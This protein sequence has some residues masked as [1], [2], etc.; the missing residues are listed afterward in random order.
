MSKIVL[1]IAL[2]IAIGIVFYVWRRKRKQSD[3]FL[4]KYVEKDTECDNCK[5]LSD[6]IANGNVIDCR[7]ISDERSHYT[8]T[9]CYHEKGI[10][11]DDLSFPQSVLTD[12]TVNIVPNNKNDNIVGH[13]T[14]SWKRDKDGKL[15][16]LEFKKVN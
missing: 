10:I 16:C 12:A 15:S 1:I 4:E 7:T 8:S 14:S 13:W 5:Y 9:F 6:C 11:V 2:V 3:V